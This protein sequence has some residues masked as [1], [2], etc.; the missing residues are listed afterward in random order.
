[1]IHGKQVSR[2]LKCSAT[3]IRYPGSMTKNELVSAW[4][5]IYRLPVIVGQN[6]NLNQ[7]RSFAP[8]DFLADVS[9]ADVFDQVA[10]P[11]G[12][13]R[14]L[15]QKHAKEAYEYAM[16][17]L[18][19]DPFEDARAFSEV[20][21]NV[22][23]VEAV[24]LEV[25]G[26]IV[27]PNTLV[28]DSGEPIFGEIVISIDKLNFPF[29][30]TDPDIS[31]VD[32]N[33]RLSSIETLG[34]RDSDKVFPIISFAM[35]IGLTKEQELKVFADINGKQQKMDTSHLNQILANQKG[36]LSL[37]SDKSRGRW[38]AKQICATGKPF[39]GLVFMG[40]SRRG[41]KKKD[42]VSPPITFTGLTTMMNHTLK[43]MEEII[44][45]ELSTK[46]CEAAAS[47]DR[48]KFEEIKRKSE[49]FEKLI[50]NFWLAVKETF[51]EAWNDKKKAEYLLFDS[52]GNVALSMLAGTMISAGVR[53]KRYGKDDFKRELQAI[54]EEGVHLRKSNFP[55]GLAGLAGTKVVY[56]SLVR[57]KDIGNS[58][59]SG[60][61]SELVPGPKSK[62]D[63]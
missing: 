34:K 50:E 7:V 5:N 28:L 17:S 22:R 31:R 11:E 36:D 35:F 53:D 56:E 60:I 49:A 62:L 54:R 18:T 10:N 12:T 40:G 38:F 39:E 52:T 57:A 15:K 13:Q 58:G 16:D 48:I 37:L 23:N 2:Q 30:N 61:I 32:G 41:L 3:A 1:M 55:S 27:D 42:G 47:G 33:H 24:E 59:L 44:A 6:L 63:G 4:G 21:L 26:K 45:K 46:D 14:E 8:L 20:I 9:A 25:D 43:G 29:E 19:A 51:P